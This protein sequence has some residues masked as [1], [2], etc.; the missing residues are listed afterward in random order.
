MPQTILPSLWFDTEA[1]E[2]AEHYCSIFPDS[3]IVGVTH[4]T[5]AAPDK[6][7]T[8]LTVDFELRGQRIT[9]LNGGPQFKFNEAVSLLVECED[10][11]EV[12][13]YWERLTDGGEERPCGWCKDRYGL[14]WQ[15]VPAV[16]SDL[17]ADDDP[18]RAQRVMEAMFPMHKLDI[19]AL[20]AAAEGAAA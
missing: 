18:A 17:L 9:A 7:G 2:A 3:R 10:Q 1:H 20:Q 15:V 16:M 14:F 5:E 13:R 6:A 4:Y 8:V 19:A 11:A 12:D